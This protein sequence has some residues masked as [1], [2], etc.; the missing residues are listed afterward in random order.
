MNGKRSE[1]EPSE[2]LVNLPAE[3][4]LTPMVGENPHIDVRDNAI[5]F[6]NN[7]LGGVSAITLGNA[8]IWNGNPYNAKDSNGPSWPD[9]R[10]AIEHE[11]QHTYQG[12]QLGPF[13]LPSNVLGGLNALVR[14]GQWHGGGNWNEVGPQQDPPRP[15]GKR[16]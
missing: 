12:E 4:K 11:K 10:K 7:P 3:L 5:Q 15:W 8:V 2:R 13:Y 9:G 16:K 6:T 14:D 1:P